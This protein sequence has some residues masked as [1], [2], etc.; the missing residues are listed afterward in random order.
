MYTGAH[1]VKR[2]RR[3]ARRVRRDE[4]AVSQSQRVNQ[5]L[6]GEIVAWEL[7]PSVHFNEVVLAA[8]LSVWRTPVR[9]ARGWFHLRGRAVLHHVCA[10]QRRRT[11]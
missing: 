3:R 10:L 4:R 9:E 8:R 7:Q 11:P 2:E 6:R 1:I 5:Q